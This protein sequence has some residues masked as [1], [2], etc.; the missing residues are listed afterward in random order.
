MAHSD[1]PLR[2]V[3]T[4]RELE[5]LRRG[6]C[7]ESERP[8]DNSVVRMLTEDHAGWDDYVVSLGEWFRQAARHG[9]EVHSHYVTEL[10]SSVSNR[11]TFLQP[12]SELMAAYFLEVQQG[13]SLRYLSRQVVPTPDFQIHKKGLDLTVEI[14]TPDSDA[15]PP[16][17]S[18]PFMAVPSAAPLLRQAMKSARRQL[19]RS[20]NNL[21]LVI[22][23]DRPI[24][25][26]EAVDAAYGD[27]RLAIPFGADGPIGEP[28]EVRD[29]NVFFQPG[30]NTRVG[31]M[32]I[33]WW[34][35]HPESAGY[36]IHNAYARNRIPDWAF[37]PWPQFVMDEAKRAMV[38][39]NRPE[40]P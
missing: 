3:F 31:A 24:Y 30:K 18:R 16:D 7:V 25:Q 4:E 20:A 15:P 12:A 19:D 9:D 10:R 11:C 40:S 27:L 17:G 21:V 39:R 37:D 35:R 28:Y 5:R 13:F 32:G 36:V 6:I 38:W 29:E 34:T 1:Y 33:L 22:A 23:Y 2:D 8:A 26:D 14:K